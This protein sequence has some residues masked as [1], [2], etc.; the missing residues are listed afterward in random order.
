MRR[1]IG[2]PGVERKPAFPKAPIDR[3]V[4]VLPLP[5]GTIKSNHLD[6]RVGTGWRTVVLVGNVKGRLGRASNSI[7]I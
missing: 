4:L 3:G 6:R 2:V 7:A 1:E 5:F